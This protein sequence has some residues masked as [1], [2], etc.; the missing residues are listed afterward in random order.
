MPGILDRL[1]RLFSTDA[2]ERGAEDD[3]IE[4]APEGV[5]ARLQ[6]SIQRQRI[7]REEEERIRR[8]G[9][10]QSRM[11]REGTQYSNIG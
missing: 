3:I 6:D 8:A 9:E 4:R 2:A 1:K 10:A 7:A 11:H 5:R